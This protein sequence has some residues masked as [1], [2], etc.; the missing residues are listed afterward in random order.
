LNTPEITHH[1]RT[2]RSPRYYI[3]VLG[4]AL[5]LISIL[6]EKKAGLRLTEIAES[7]Q[8]DKATALRILHTLQRHG[9]VVRD[10][11]SK[12]FTLPLGYRQFRIGYAQLCGGQPFSEAVTQSLVTEAKGSFVE[13]IVADNEYDAQKAIQN[14]EWMIQ[15]RVDFAIEFQIHYRTA[16]LLAHMFGRARI[17]TLAIDIPQPGAI[18]FGA[19]NYVAGLMAGE[20]LGRAVQKK[21]RGRADKLLLLETFVAG[22][23]PHARVTGT[24][25]GI[26]NILSHRIHLRVARRD[27]NDTEAGGYQA[28]VKFLRGL[29][30]RNRLL[31]ATVNDSS[32]LGA[33]RAVREAGHERF[34]AIIG[35]NF[36]PDPRVA[37]ELRNRNSPLIGSIAFFPEQYGSKIL[38]TVLRWLNKEQVAPAI[39]TDH[40]LVTTENIDEFCPEAVQQSTI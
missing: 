28:T 23:T 1:A 34:T 11:R 29:S 20:A 5:G 16:P 40:V 15:Q 24:L 17:P 8:L 2:N 14:A 36:S 32:A 31:I 12:R 30:T 35:Q 33:L 18:Y 22:P 9:W 27:A 13:L 39:Y 19:N 25:R 6:R 3:K 26:R 10:H 21:W 4:K 37:A 38:P 7:S